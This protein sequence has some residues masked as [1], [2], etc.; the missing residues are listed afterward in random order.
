MLLTHQLR[1]GF[2][3]FWLTPDTKLGVHYFQYLT[4]DFC[5]LP[6]THPEY[7]L[8]ICLS[9]GVEF[10]FRSGEREIM[11]AGDII[12]LNPGQVHRSQYGLEKTPCE[13]VGLIINKTALQDIL[14]QMQFAGYQRAQQ[15]VFPGKAH[16]TKVV[17]LTNEL[18][19]ELQERNK[20]FGLV[21]KSLVVQILVYLLRNCLEPTTTPAEA[22]LPR[23]LPHWELS[24]AIE[25]MNSHGNDDF[26]LP[27][28]CAETGCSSSRFVP[29]FKNSTGLTPHNYYRKLLMERARRLLTSGERSIKEVAYELGFRNLGHFYGVFQSVFE[30]TPKT[31]RL[32]EGAKTQSNFV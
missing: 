22:E 28:L 16:D 17:H 27:E 11:K 6:H 29:L 19:Y 2:S 23:Q 26:S 12:M 32:L 21:M 24:R 25:Y 13:T 1:E 10:I 9:G 4:N 3:K 8:V 5:Y 18:L 20:G 31:C 14:V 7:N 30:M 15:V